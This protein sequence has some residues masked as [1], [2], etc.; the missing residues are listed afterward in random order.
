LFTA[1]YGSSKTTLLIES[2]RMDGDKK[3]AKYFIQSKK[4][5]SRIY[6]TDCL[7]AIF[8]QYAFKD[9]DKNYRIHRKDKATV[10][11]YQK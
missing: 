10:K 3:E 4:I 11:K 6:T 9:S 7:S 1:R 5:Y 2:G 8:G